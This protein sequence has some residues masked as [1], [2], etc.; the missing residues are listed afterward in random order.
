MKDTGA[1]DDT[2]VEEATKSVK[3][4]CPNC[5]H[6]MLEGKDGEVENVRCHRCKKRYDI[7]IEKGKA[8]IKEVK[9]K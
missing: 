8:N 9:T 7:K 6:Y 3:V 4:N 1:P 5:K 2:E